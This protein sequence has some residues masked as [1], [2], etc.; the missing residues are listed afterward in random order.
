MYP[1][2]G[3]SGP[4]PGH[5]RRPHPVAV[6]HLQRSHRQAM[7]L[8]EPIRTPQRPHLRELFDDVLFRLAA[9]GDLLEDRPLL[10]GRVGAEHPQR[11]DAVEQELVESGLDLVLSSTGLERLAGAGSTS[12]IEPQ[13][14]AC[15][16][17]AQGK[18]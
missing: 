2:I 9:S 10:L 5:V 4:E 12:P 11:I 1:A 16:G 15:R 3:V 6:E 13:G 17:I 8:L 18:R 14:S 7:G